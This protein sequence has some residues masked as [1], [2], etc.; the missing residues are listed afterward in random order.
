MAK[1]QDANTVTSSP[2]ALRTTPEAA[3]YLKY[4]PSTMNQL[5]WKGCGPRFVRIGRSVRY[6]QSDLDAFID[7]QVFSSTTEADASLMRH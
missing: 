7:A 4:K 2:I 1:Q 5:R 3:A 6:R